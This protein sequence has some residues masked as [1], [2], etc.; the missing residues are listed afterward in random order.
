MLDEALKAGKTAAAR[1]EKIGDAVI[2]VSDSST[3]RVFNADPVRQIRQAVLSTSNMPMHDL[4]GSETDTQNAILSRVLTV[5]C[6]RPFGI[7]DTVP[8]W[9]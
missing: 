8:H 5:T 7:L 9:L 4:V 6:D 2:A 1:A 3:R